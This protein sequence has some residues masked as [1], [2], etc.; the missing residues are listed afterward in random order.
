MITNLLVIMQGIMQIKTF[1][2]LKKIIID[3][4]EPY[5]F[6]GYQYDEE[7]IS[8]LGRKLIKGD[9][10]GFSAF[11]EFTIDLYDQGYQA[12]NFGYMISLAQHYGIPTNLVDLTDDP[13]VAL[14]FGM[15][16]ES[17]KRR[18]FNVLFVKK[19]EF[20]NSHGNRA[21]VRKNILGDMMEY[22]LTLG[23]D[24]GLTLGQTFEFGPDTLMNKDFLQSKKFECDYRKFFTVQ[25]DFSFIPHEENDIIRLKEQRGLFL[26]A[27][28][29][30]K[31]IPKEWFSIL[32][33]DLSQNE[34]DILCNYLKQNNYNAKMLL[35][36]VDITNKI[37]IKETADKIKH[38]Y[39]T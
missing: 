38:K 8:S 17:N 29:A 2:E 3:V 21:Q 15:G 7:L 5:Y 16:G 23:D 4:K 35:P 33:V 31:P 26:M 10:D 37:N 18:K 34:V 28:D 19:N 30:K 27:A 24:K 12:H 14:Y 36:E 20:E 25:K 9:Y 39:E 22:G 13:L 32:E 1:E 6:R 11:K